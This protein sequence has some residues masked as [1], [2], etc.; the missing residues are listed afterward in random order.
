ML[1]CVVRACMGVGRRVAGR[2]S[3]VTPTGLLLRCS[4]NG[5]SREAAV[6]YPR[7]WIHI[8]GRRTGCTAS[9]GQG[10][11]F[12]LGAGLA[13]SKTWAYCALRWQFRCEGKRS[14]QVGAIASMAEKSTL[15]IGLVWPPDAQEGPHEVTRIPRTEGSLKLR[16]SPR[17]YGPFTDLLVWTES[18]QQGHFCRQQLHLET[19]PTFYLYQGSRGTELGSESKITFVL[20]DGGSLTTHTFVST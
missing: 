9:A 15:H 19:Q 5:G 18:V 16:L 14:T 2:A 13:A 3:S 20:G 10:W 1:H 17:P 8:A 4:Q 7:R 12:L 6:G 11:A